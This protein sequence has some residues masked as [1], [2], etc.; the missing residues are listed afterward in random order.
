MSAKP[1]EFEYHGRP[2]KSAIWKAPIAGSIAARGVNLVGDEQVDRK[3]HGRP[4]DCSLV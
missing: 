4:A 3:A 2:A 1:R